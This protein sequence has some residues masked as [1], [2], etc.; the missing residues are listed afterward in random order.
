MRLDIWADCLQPLTEIAALGPL[1][2]A[3]EELMMRPVEHMPKDDQAV[4]AALSGMTDANALA[5][6]RALRW[7]ASERP[8]PSAPVT[9]AQLR[10]RV[11]LL[12]SR[13]EDEDMQALDRLLAALVRQSAPPGLL[14]ALR[15]SLTN[16]K[17][18]GE[19]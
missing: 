10:D 2:V 12:A 9:V 14:A 6:L 17:P 11:V 8:E 19:A 18:E 4:L 3:W 5:V 16:K 7:W 13:G 1:K 15:A